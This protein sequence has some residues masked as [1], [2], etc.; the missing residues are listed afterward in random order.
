M[1]LSNQYT[2]YKKAKLSTPVMAMVVDGL[3]EDC[4]SI[5]SLVSLL[6]VRAVVITIVPAKVPVQ[7]LR[8]NFCDSR[9]DLRTSTAHNALGSQNNK[10]LIGCRSGPSGN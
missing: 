9:I 10:N 7:P 5:D 6:I 4:G 8:S 3:V 2:V 1:L